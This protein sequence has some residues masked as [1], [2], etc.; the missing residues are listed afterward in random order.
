MQ[1]VTRRRLLADLAGW[2]QSDLEPGNKNPS[3]M[4]AMK[5]CGVTM[6][7]AW[8]ADDHCS[9]MA[10][11]GGQAVT[12]IVTN[13]LLPPPQGVHEKTTLTGQSAGHAALW[14]ATCMLPP[15]I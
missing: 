10:T 15:K 5:V 12:S 9:E 4:D 2:D 1:L 3:V 13:L 6:P 11:I 8:T 7:P 14:G